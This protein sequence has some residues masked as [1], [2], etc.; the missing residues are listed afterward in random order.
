[1]QLIYRSTYIFQ[2]LL[3]MILVLIYA[4]FFAPHGAYPPV[5]YLALFIFY[6]LA[7]NIFDV[8]GW[9]QLIHKWK[10]DWIK[11]SYNIK[12]EIY[13]ISS[14]QIINNSNYVSEFVKSSII[15]YRIMQFMFQFL[16]IGFIVYL[17]NFYMLIPILVPWLLGTDDL[18]YYVLAKE[19]FPTGYITW[20]NW[21]IHGIL[22]KNKVTTIKFVIVGLIGLIIGLVSCFYI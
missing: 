3:I 19:N 22:W 11:P 12:I 8:L 13:D 1:M 9:G 4:L 17:S 14:N 15:S 21:T 20:L 10:M 2:S 16:L 7:F 18:I 5:F 6:R